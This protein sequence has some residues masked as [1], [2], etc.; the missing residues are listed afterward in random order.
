VKHSDSSA[1]P[2]ARAV[3]GALGNPGIVDDARVVGAQFASCDD[4]ERAVADAIAGAVGLPDSSS[5]IDE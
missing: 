5:L 1:L 3:L 2:L 4:L